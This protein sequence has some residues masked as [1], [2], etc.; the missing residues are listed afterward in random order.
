MKTGQGP[1]IPEVIYYYSSTNSVINLNSVDF[2]VICIAHSPQIGP[3]IL[4]LPSILL[5]SINN[6]RQVLA[7]NHQASTPYKL[8]WLS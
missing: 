2:L 4:F 5:L 3:T 7:N 6:N 8:E 1:C